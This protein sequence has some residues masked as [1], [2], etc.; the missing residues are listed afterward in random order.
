MKK[1]IKDCAIVGGK[2]YNDLLDRGTRKKNTEKKE[3]KKGK[4]KKKKKK[5]EKKR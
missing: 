4:K 5:E 1:D 3:K 2:K